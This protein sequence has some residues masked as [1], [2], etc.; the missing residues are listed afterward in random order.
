MALTDQQDDRIRKIVRDEIRSALNRL[1]RVREGEFAADEVIDDRYIRSLRISKL[2]A[3]ELQVDMNI[4]AGG[5][6]S[7]GGAR[8]DDGGVKLT[9]LSEQRTVP[10]VDSGSKITTDESTPRHA[11]AYYQM[12]PDP[13][14]V[15]L[16]GAETVVTAN[17]DSERAD[18]LMFA[19][20]DPRFPDDINSAYVHA[21]S[22]YPGLEG[23]GRVVLSY[24]AYV[25]G[26]LDVGGLL[27]P[28]VPAFRSYKTQDQGIGANGSGTVY[29]Q[30]YDYNIGGLGLYTDRIVIPSGWGGIWSFGV[31]V[32]IAGGFLQDG[33]TARLFL[34]LRRNGNAVARENIA[35]DYGERVSGISVADQFHC[36]A[37]DQI[38]VSFNWNTNANNGLTLLGNGVDSA[39]WGHYVSAY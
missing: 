29:W 28:R 4:T 1:L 37:G 20:E 11:F 25:R 32:G 36:A 23:A 35:T 39:F 22:S 2:Q 34:Q 33:E 17:P 8:M 27:Q 14:G 19:G 5:S 15:T 26:N 18:V 13:N 6:I 30:T 12:P 24:D 21:A 9:R 31:R 7:A 16:R 3:G 38:S 10:T